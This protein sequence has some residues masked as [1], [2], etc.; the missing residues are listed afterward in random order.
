MTRIFDGMAKFDKILMGFVSTNRKHHH[1][2]VGRS[3]NDGGV[4]TDSV[5]IKA[6]GHGLL[7]LQVYFVTVS[8]S[9]TSVR[10]VMYNLR[11][12]RLITLR[13]PKVSLCIGS[14]SELYLAVYLYP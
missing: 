4:S 12:A 10:Y 14:I 13:F 11:S 9:T 3:S 5:G 1:E 7:I 6:F 2:F 8:S